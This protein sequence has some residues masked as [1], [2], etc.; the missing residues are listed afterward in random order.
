[1]EGDG[2]MFGVCYLFGGNGL[3]VISLCIMKRNIDKYE[4]VT[5]LPTTALTVAD[6]AAQ[7]N[8]N[9]SYIYK[10]IRN[11]KAAFKI[12]SFHGINFIIP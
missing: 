3:Q 7:R 9:T 4:N 2:G 10:L 11:G 8:C 1:M 12:V 5:K 6:Y